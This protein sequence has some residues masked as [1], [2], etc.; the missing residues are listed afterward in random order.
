VKLY[1]N[2]QLPQRG[3][4]WPECLGVALVVVA[5]VAGLGVT[6]VHL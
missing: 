2:P 5:A 3:G 6:V 4:W 1:P